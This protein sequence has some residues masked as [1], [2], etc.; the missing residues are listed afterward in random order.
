MKYVVRPCMSLTVTFQ[1]WYTVR[2]ATLRIEE[3]DALLS[4]PSLATPLWPSLVMVAPL[5]SIIAFFILA[6]PVIT[7]FAPSLNVRQGDSYNQAIAVPTVNFAMAYDAT[8]DDLGITYDDGLV[9]ESWD[10]A[11]MQGLMS[12]TPIGWK[13]PADCSPACNYTIRYAAAAPKCIDL[14]PNRISNGTVAFDGIEPEA[15]LLGYD[16]GFMEGSTALNFTTQFGHDDEEYGWTLAY[17]EM[18]S[19]NNPHPRGTA[20]T[21]HNA[22]YE[23]VVSY[24]NGTQSNTVRVAEYHDKLNTTYLFFTE[25][26]PDDHYDSLGIKQPQNR[27]YK[28][29]LSPTDIW[30]NVNLIIMAYALSSHLDGSIIYGDGSYNNSQRSLITKTNLFAL[31]RGGEFTLKDGITNISQSLMDLVANV[32]LNFMNL[33]LGNMTVVATL[34]STDSVYLYH[35]HLLIG[36]YVTAFVILLASGVIGM[37]CLVSN[38]VPSSNNFS[39]IL[40]T[41]RN[42]TLDVLAKGT[43]LGSEAVNRSSLTG[44][45]LRFGEVKVDGWEDVKHAAFGAVDYEDVYT[46]ETGAAY[47]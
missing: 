43:C 26:V 30:S 38:G 28:Q 18:D 4:P 33:D 46:L 7:V 3:L 37:L 35:R 29:A 21:F 44:I 13:I 34:P 1:S 32:T 14:S 2:R 8:S 25:T 15:Y 17:V 20:C 39:Q 23:T 42:P 16:S 11:T 5:A 40:A 24:I 45:R 12:R 31:G 9:S 10:T 36:T 27:N 41:T 19:E 6:S 22:T 47:S